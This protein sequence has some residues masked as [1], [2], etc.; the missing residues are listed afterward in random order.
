MIKAYKIYT[1]SDGHSHI[2]SGS[3]SESYLTSVTAISFNETKAC[4]SYDW[5]T[6]PLT[7]YVICLTGTLLF[8][9]RPG[10]TFI[11]RPGEIL[12]AMDT[13]GTGHKWK[14]IDDQPWRR[15]Y[16]I[17]DDTAQINFVEDE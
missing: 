10:E 11:L 17:F 13:T 7:Q 6:A 2:V 9:T 12:I 3:V 15:A 14:L 1:G 16:V 8:E 4:S 5:H